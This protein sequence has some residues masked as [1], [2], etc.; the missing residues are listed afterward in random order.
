L[1]LLLLLGLLVT[2]PAALQLAGDLRWHLFR[3][4]ILRW[5][6]LA[7]AALAALAFMLPAGL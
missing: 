3:A 2:V 4:P 7:S 5:L 1:D 6:A